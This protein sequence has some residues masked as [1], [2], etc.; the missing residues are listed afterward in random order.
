MNTER[1]SPLA[2]DRQLI[3]K[4]NEEDG[5][6][7]ERKKSRKKIDKQSLASDL[8]KKIMFGED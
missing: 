4:G 7:T 8:Q 6:F 2:T 5:D 3:S 1:E